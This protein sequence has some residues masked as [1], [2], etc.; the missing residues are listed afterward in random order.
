[1][2]RAQAKSEEKPAG[3][4]IRLVPKE[5]ADAG[6][7]FAS[8]SAALQQIRSAGQAAAQ[9]WKDVEEAGFSRLGWKMAIS[10]LRKDPAAAQVIFKGMFELLQHQN[11][12]AKD[13]KLPEFVQKELP[14][15]SDA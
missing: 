1:M 11:F 6:K 8:V 9:V 14:L 7:H 12:I 5:S 2:A 15:G 3:R 10:L 13:A 4:T